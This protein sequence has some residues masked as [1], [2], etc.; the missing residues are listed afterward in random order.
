MFA[1]A[2]QEFLAKAFLACSYFGTFEM[3]VGEMAQVPGSRFGGLCSDVCL[4]FLS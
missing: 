3:Q 2:S 1:V 4:L